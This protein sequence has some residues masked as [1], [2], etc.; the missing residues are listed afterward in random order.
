M[1][2]ESIVESGMWLHPYSGILLSMG[3]QVNII[4]TSALPQSQLS[5]RNA[6]VQR[7]AAAIGNAG[8][9]PIVVPKGKKTAFALNLP[10]VR[11]IVFTGEGGADERALFQEA[12]FNNVPIVAI[13][14]GL[15]LANLALG[16]SCTEAM[17]E[18]PSKLRHIRIVPATMLAEMAARAPGTEVNA[19]YQQAIVKLAEQFVPSAFGDEGIVEA[20]ESE[21]GHPGFF[22]GVRWH[23]ETLPSEPLSQTIFRIFVTACKTGY[24]N[25]LLPSGQ[26]VPAEQ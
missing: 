9:H 8:A 1:R 7:Y 4:V 23:P 16:G 20:I 15:H 14:R 17:G 18:R 19:A 12:Y 5:Q 2:R 24:K 11:G 10:E 22:L 21:E 13:D 25:P 6:G 26:G 3:E